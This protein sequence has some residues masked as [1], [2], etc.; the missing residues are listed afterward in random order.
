M[1]NKG[2]APGDALSRESD[3]RKRH[4]HPPEVG[5]VLRPEREAPTA[6]V[7]RSKPAPPLRPLKPRGDSTAATPIPPLQAR[8]HAVV[9]A[10]RRRP[11]ARPP[12]L[13]ADTGGHPPTAL[14]AVTAVDRAPPN[15]PPYSCRPLATPGTRHRGAPP[16]E[17]RSG[18]RRATLTPRHLDAAPATRPRHHGVD[19]YAR[20]RAV[21]PQTPAAPRPPPRRGSQ[22]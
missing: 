16:R 13:S 21:P 5:K 20:G 2:A 18:S 10:P 7:R 19:A 22:P 8:H 15:Q 14:S 12:P 11:A 3:A 9:H 6:R 17:P 1:C 4:R